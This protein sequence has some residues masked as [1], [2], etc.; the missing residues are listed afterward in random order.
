MNSAEMNADGTPSTRKAVLLALKRG[1]AQSVAQIAKGL[2]VTTMAIRVHLAVLQADG[3]V[4]FTEQRSKVGRPAR[5]WGLKPK[6]DNRFPDFH[7]ELAAGMLQAIRSTFGEE[8]LERLMEEMTRQQLQN[9]RAQMPGSDASLDER[10]AA[11]ARIRREE[12]YM[13]DWERHHDGTVMLVENHCSIAKAARICPNLCSCELS[14]FRAVMGDDVSLE[15]VEHIL[16]GDRCCTYRI[17]D[18]DSGD[19]RI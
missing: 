13:A 6:A 18:R 4:D 12:G 3:L 9:Y 2:G 17:T 5:F 15:R 11:L 14:L 19:G 1:G 10:V 8:G 7:A 16:S